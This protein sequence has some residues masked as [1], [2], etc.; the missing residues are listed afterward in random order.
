M[1]KFFQVM[2]TRPI[3]RSVW[4]TILV[5][6]AAMALVVASLL[7]S[8]GLA[9][10]GV[11]PV[12]FVGALVAMK[13]GLFTF[14]PEVSRKGRDAGVALRGIF[15]TDDSEGPEASLREEKE[16][17]ALNRKSK[18]PGGLSLWDQHDPRLDV[19]LFSATVPTFVLSQDQRFLDWNPAFELVFGGLEGVRRGAHVSHWF[20]HLD[21][22]RRVP[23][24]TDKLYGEG[25]LPITDRERVA[26]LSKLYGRMVFTKIMSPIV[27]RGSGRIIGWTVVLN[28]NSVNKRQEFFERLFA[29]ISAETRRIRF[30]ASHD[31]LFDG[32]KARLTL[33]Q[34][35]LED[36]E[37]A[38]R[39]LEIGSGTGMMTETMVADGRKVTAVEGD[40]H[41]LRRL[42]DKC[43]GFESRVRLVRQDPSVLK[44]VPVARFDAAVLF[45]SLHRFDDPAKVLAHVYA[46]LKP[47]AILSISFRL[48]GIE[49]LYN[50]VKTHLD[51]S[52]RYDQL[53]HQF[54]HVLEFER[55]LA[56]STPYRFLSRE[57]ARALVLEAG[58]NLESE[59]TGLQ[60]GHTLLLKAR[61]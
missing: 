32:Y 54:N 45:E 39:V 36:L 16:L 13:L 56:T 61:K 53:K 21:N 4:A 15:T 6:A 25:I 22:F 51:A 43:E 20:Q 48:D 26:Y 41:Q 33:M 7:E 35:H 42:K 57:E 59:T 23:K 38:V 1:R 55:E 46:S 49:P 29:D 44:G 3:S 11:G 14:W 27:D 30:A 40:V 47:G 12:S 9:G 34:A 31:G 5:A 10:P 37:E 52:D 24:R 58:F 28:I 17:Y 60:D 50:S 8:L 18:R 2:I 19:S